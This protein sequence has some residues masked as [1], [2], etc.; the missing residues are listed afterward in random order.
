MRS[1]IACLPRETVMPSS[2]SATS[3]KS[4]MTSAVKNSPIAA[5]ATIAIV[6]DNSIVMRREIRFSNASLKIWPTADKQAD[7]TDHADAL[8]RLPDA[9]PHRRGRYGDERDTR[10]FQP[11]EGMVV[12]DFMF[13]MLVVTHR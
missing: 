12:L 7:H 3:T 13:V 11:L 5:A 2:T 8:D 9:K 1:W 6:I 4:A 10:C